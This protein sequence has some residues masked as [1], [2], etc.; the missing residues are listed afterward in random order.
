MYED[1]KTAYRK[2]NKM[3]HSNDKSP[4]T[5]PIQTAFSPSVCKR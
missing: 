1:E 2:V 3:K 5:K 4:K